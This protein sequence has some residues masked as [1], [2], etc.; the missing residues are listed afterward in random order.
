MLKYLHDYEHK[1]GLNVKHNT[2][3]MNIHEI[4]VVDQDQTSAR[5]RFND[6]H[7]NIYTCR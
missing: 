1:L 6:Q 2:E 3:V 4:S 5:F 7:G